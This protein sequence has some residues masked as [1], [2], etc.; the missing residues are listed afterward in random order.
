MEIFDVNSIRFVFFLFVCLCCWCRRLAVM[1]IDFTTKNF[2]I[3]NLISLFFCTKISATNLLWVVFL[4]LRWQYIFSHCESLLFQ[5]NFRSLYSISLN[6]FDVYWNICYL[7]L[8]I[9]MNIF[10]IKKMN[11]CWTNKML[12]EV[13][14]QKFV[15]L[16]MFSWQ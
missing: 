4:L 8:I 12:Y 1:N 13:S 2:S 9:I 16:A 5:Q 3:L 15:W 14:Q 11:S 6:S 10:F 7:D